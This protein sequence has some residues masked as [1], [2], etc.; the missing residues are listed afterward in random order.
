MTTFPEM[1]ADLQKELAEREAEY[2]DV[3]DMRRQRDAAVGALKSCVDVMG[4]VATGGLLGDKF[5]AA[6]NAAAEIIATE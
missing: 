2:V 6:R 5:L 1:V 4:A 3:D